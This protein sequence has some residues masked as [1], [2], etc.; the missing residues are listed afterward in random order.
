M[1]LR[2]MLGFLAGLLV[3]VGLPG[4]DAPLWY[5]LLWSVYTLILCFGTAHNLADAV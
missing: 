5:F 1:R 4:D 2:Q 3:I